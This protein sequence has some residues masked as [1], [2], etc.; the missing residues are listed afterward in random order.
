MPVP[1]VA[2]ARVNRRPV[3]PG[4][5]SYRLLDWVARLGASG[6]EPA[7][8]ALGL[9][10]SVVYSHT[11]RLIDAGLMWRVPINDGNGG[12]VAVTRRGAADARDRGILAIAPRSQAPSSGVH[13]RAVSWVAAR[14]LMKEWTWLGPAEL[15]A[16][17]GWDLAR[18]DGSKHRPDLGLFVGERAVAVE[19]ELH[20]KASD[21]LTAILRA[22]H[23]KLE[24]GGLDAVS[25]V[26][27]KQH[28][29][30]MLHR[31][32]NKEFLFLKERAGVDSLQRIIELVRNDEEVEA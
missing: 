2:Q 9:S 25:Y 12:V 28:V 26:T 7:G 15:G 29:A 13:A 21:R 24:Y 3:R 6:I 20:A 30:R 5:G 32:I 14:A 22:Y 16:A 19:V 10:R 27:D 4:P 1:E 23:A 18:G 31:H 8:F 11:S 17:R